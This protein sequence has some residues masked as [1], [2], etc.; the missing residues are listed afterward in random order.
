MN[1]HRAATICTFRREG[2]ELLVNAH[3][4][5]YLPTSPCFRGI[6]L[7]ALFTTMFD[8]L[9][10]PQFTNKNGGHAYG[11]FTAMVRPPLG[12]DRIFNLRSRCRRARHGHLEAWRLSSRDASARRNSCSDIG[13]PRIL[14]RFCRTGANVSRSPLRQSRASNR[15]VFNQVRF[16]LSVFAKVGA[17]WILLPTRLR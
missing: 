1:S 16:L 6:I 10:T 11:K 12:I 14:R 13:L 9:S 15:E 8:F 5:K 17:R 7:L 4:Q 3:E 2:L